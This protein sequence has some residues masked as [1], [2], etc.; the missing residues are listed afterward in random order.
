MTRD[1][2]VKGQ[3]WRAGDQILL[4]HAAANRDPK[5]FPNPDR[6]D[7]DRK[8]N[9]HL[10]FGVGPHRCVGSNHAKVMFEVMI[11]EILCRLPDFEIAGEIEYFPDGG[12]VWAVQR[13]PI[14]FTPGARSSDP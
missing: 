13:L 5:V 7:F 10:A 8:P 9:R 4:C 12:D 14:R 6:I 2:V 1:C 11:S 3:Q